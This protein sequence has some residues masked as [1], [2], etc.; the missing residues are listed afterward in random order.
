MKDGEGEKH[1]MLNRYRSE[2]RRPLMI[3]LSERFSVALVCV[4]FL[5]GGAAVAQE[6]GTPTTREMNYLCWQEFGELVPELINTV[7]VPLGSLEPHGVIPNGTDNL[8]PES[9]ARDIADRTNAL[10][11]PTLNYGITPAMEAYP[12]AVS[13]SADAYRNF[14]ADVL[15]SLAD[16]QFRN[17]ILL[18][19]H[20]GNTATLQ[21]LVTEMSN[22]KQVRMLLV[23]W[24]S[25]TSD[26]A[27]EVFGD[28]GGHAASNE[29]AYMQ[30][31]YPEHIH[32]ERYSEDMTMS[33]D[34]AWS[35]SPV[36][37]T[38]SL[39]VEGEG[40]PTFDQE[41]ADLFFERVN[42][43]VA[44]LINDVISRWERAGVN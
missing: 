24:W 43:R 19:G 31:S 16:N 15:S 11:A 30:A 20:G 41:Q 2:L 14:V 3:R 29:T 23:N 22:R 17:I 26:I 6:A 21:S 28:I 4:G 42:S 36:P 9:M 27:Q 5:C 25:L 37:Y 35:A 34:P 38:I 32:S 40:Y 13:I 39:Y 44:D 18:N 1:P 12:G 10:I 33:T 7:L 8:A